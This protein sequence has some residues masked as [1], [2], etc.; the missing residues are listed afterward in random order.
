MVLTMAREHVRESALALWGLFKD[1]LDT[2]QGPR[3]VEKSMNH[4]HGP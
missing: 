3:D 2:A 4:L 1:N